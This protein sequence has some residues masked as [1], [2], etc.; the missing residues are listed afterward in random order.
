MIARQHGGVGVQVR[1]AV[2]VA[3]RRERPERLRAVLFV[4]AFLQDVVLHHRVE[5]RLPGLRGC[6]VAQQ[7]VRCSRDTIH[8]LVAI[9]SWP[10]Q[11]SARALYGRW[12]LLRSFCKPFRLLDR[13]TTGGVPSRCGKSGLL[14]SRPRFA[15]AAACAHKTPKTLRWR[16][17]LTSQQEAAVLA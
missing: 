3:E 6:Q 7:H 15:I 1:K 4:E 2:D 9:A 8:V 13:A 12:R 10:P 17:R 11:T 5:E 14:V 16:A